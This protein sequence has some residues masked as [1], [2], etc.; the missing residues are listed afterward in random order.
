MDKHGYSTKGLPKIFGTAAGTKIRDIS[1][2]I[3]MQAA[4]F[5]AG[6]IFAGVTIF[7]G[8]RP[9][10]LAFGAACATKKGAAAAMSG[11]FLG[12]AFQ[13]GNGLQYCASLLVCATCALVFTRAKTPS[14]TVFMPFCVCLSLLCTGAVTLFSGFSPRTFVLLLCEVAIGASLTY[15]FSLG[16][17][18]AATGTRQSKLYL[19]GA[20]S[21]LLALLLALQGVQFFG[22][23]S[24]SRVLAMACVMAAAYCGGSAAGAACGVAFGAAFDLSGG[25]QPYFAGIYG[26]SGLFAG[27][28][29][30]ESKLSFSVCYV[31]AN[32]LASLWGMGLLGTSSP[33]YECFIAS[34]IF[35]VMPQ[36]LLTFFRGAFAPAAA[37]ET[38]EG[39][40]RTAKRT[41]A[42]LAR[43]RMALGEIAGSL[44]NF[45]KSGR[46]NDED[47]AQVFRRAADKACR[48]CPVCTACWDRDY[49]ATFGALNDVTTMLRQNRKLETADFPIYFSSR[50]INISSFTGAVND[51]YS[52][53]LRRLSQKAKGRETQQ[54][55]KKQFDG[56][57]G[58]LREVEQGC[59]PEQDYPSLEMRAQKVA[60]A[61]F[62][63]PI[64]SLF[65][66]YGRM[67]VDIRLQ[68]PEN[69]PTDYEAFIKS[70]ALALGRKF[71]LPQEIMAQRGVLLRTVEQDKYDVRVD[72]EEQKKDGESVSGDKLMHFETEDGRAIIMLS[73]G[74]GSGSSAAQ[75]SGETLDFIAKFAKAGCALAESALAV[76]PALCAR[77]AERGFV[78]LDLL[79]INL[80]TGRCKITK[81][82]AA[83]SYIL[84]GGKT[85]TL[86]SRA[87]PAGLENSN[88]GQ[89]EEFDLPGTCT[90]FM[91]SD[92]V[93]ESV[94]ADYLRSESAA[95]ANPTS[96]CKGAIEFATAKASLPADDMTIISISVCRTS[97]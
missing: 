77:M 88:S 7:D 14:S 10:G 48:A 86:L 51:E 76:T 12:Y 15:F 65:T 93:S 33:L 38:H 2:M 26:F 47:I 20:A 30:G 94:D 42:Q 32:M 92:G 22:A 85:R 89:T 13:Q 91:M 3:I 35:I 41:A 67:S 18:P 97:E 69:A 44:G 39:A 6:F 19:A 75:T 9:M 55:M 78:T 74:M 70:L 36:K 5:V 87:L 17:S 58:I 62:H 28:S 96:L 37:I 49:V 27:M 31:I 40:H 45:A 21:L 64:C 1:R 79:E 25:M 11:A 84:A 16:M 63:R 83:P 81:Y 80:L 60:S 34:I 72:F 95:N 50:C 54:L 68:K 23:I 56:A 90:I 82:G 52:E 66:Q 46:S 8:A 59:A 43:A 61:Y 73:D 57:I 29:H 71:A 4:M 24:P 53:F